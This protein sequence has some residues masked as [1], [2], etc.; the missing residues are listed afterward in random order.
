MAVARSHGMCNL[1]LEGKDGA[2]AAVDG[3]GDARLRLVADGAGRVPAHRRGHPRQHLRH[4]AGAEHFV[5]GRELRR[6]AAAV[7]PPASSAEVRREHAPGHA[8]PPQELARAARR[9]GSRR[10]RLLRL[11]VGRC[12]LARLQ[13][14]ARH[15]RILLCVH[16]PCT[17][18]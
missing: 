16:P 10:R 9:P 1:V 11:R 17:S 12:A 2:D 18:S 8:P 3:V 5:H 6:A 14:D 4:V 13:H 15:A 7:L